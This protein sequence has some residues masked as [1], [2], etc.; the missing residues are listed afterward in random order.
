[1]ICFP[2]NFVKSVSI[3]NKPNH[4]ATYNQGTSHTDSLDIE[5]NAVSHS[6]LLQQHFLGNTPGHVDFYAEVERTLQTLDEQFLSFQ[7]WKALKLKQK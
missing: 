1:M 7:Q 3:S 6:A 5:K 2:H 4:I